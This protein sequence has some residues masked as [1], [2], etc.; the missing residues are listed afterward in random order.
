MAPPSAPDP[1]WDLALDPEARTDEDSVRRRDASGA[2]LVNPAGDDGRLG[3][4]Y[5]DYLGLDALLS[6]GEPATTVPDERAFLAIHQLCEVVF[7]LMLIDLGVIAGTLAHLADASGDD[8][9]P[10]ATEPMPDESGPSAFWRPA[11]T[12]A[13]RLRHSA[14]R[15]LP[16]IMPYVGRGDDDDVLFSSIE[17]AL[18][19]YALAPSS[20]FQTAQLRLIQ[21]ALAKGPLLDLPVF[22]GDTFGQAYAG[23]PVGHVALGDP[24]VLQA[25]HSRAFPADGT[26]QARVAAL[27]PLAHRVMAR[28]A[29]RASGDHPPPRVRPLYP[30]EVERAAARFRQTLGASPEAEEIA[31]A[32]R[33]SL[34]SAADLENERRQ[35]LAQARLGAA[36]LHGPLRGTCLAFVFD[37][38]AATDHALHAPDG[39]SFLTVHRKAVRRHVAGDAG[40]GGGGMPYLVTSQRY[41]LPLF[42]RPRGVCRPRDVRGRRPRAVVRRPLAAQPLV[43]RPLARRGALRAERVGQVRSP[44]PR[45]RLVHRRVDA[46]RLAVVLELECEHLRDRHIPLGGALDQSIVPVPSGDLFLDQRLDLVGRDEVPDHA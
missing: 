37:R 46:R 15:V 4:D 10:L 45:E 23:C 25:G 3:L 44:Q 27:D 12:A 22:P 20:G 39:D 30:D 2:P 16:A 29:E 21:R 11:L 38:V 19:R 18:F 13:A 31:E 35:R 26:P 8:F 33:A 17:F 41:L 28:L 7:R 24:L 9:E 36:A 43:R 32:F 5:S 34:A 14:R 40:T 6:A 42:P 1:W